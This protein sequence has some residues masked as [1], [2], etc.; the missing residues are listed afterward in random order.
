[1][2]TNFIIPIV[3]VFSALTFT[4]CFGV[5]DDFIKVKSLVMNSVEGRYHE[6]V[7]FSVGSVG[8]SFARFVVSIDDN[9]QDAQA[10]LRNISG[11][12]IGVYKRNRF[13][14]AEFKFPSLKK[15]DQRM[16]DEN[17]YN[18]VKHVD[19]KELT[20][21]YIKY[22]DDEINQVYVINIEDED[23]TIVRVEGNLENLIEYAIKEKG[24]KNFNY[25]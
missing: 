6:D 1:M 7:E 21:V 8:I 18:V 23:L 9:D 2:K 22:E 17:W 14:N 25:R 24:L 4:G 16:R 3:I 15:L 19:G 10:V 12:Q 11:A 13:T 5:D 20:G